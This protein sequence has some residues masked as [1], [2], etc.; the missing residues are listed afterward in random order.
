MGLSTRVGTKLRLNKIRETRL[1]FF[2]FSFKTA[3]R[4]LFPGSVI[5]T[6]LVII[7]LRKFFY[8]LHYKNLS[9]LHP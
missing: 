9:F 3:T 1:I 4:E 7:V 5:S 8:F 2:E 6:V